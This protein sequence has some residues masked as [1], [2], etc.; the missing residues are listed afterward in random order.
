MILIEAKNVCKEFSKQKKLIVLE[1]FNLKVKKNEFV[2][3]IGPSGCGKSTFLLLAAGLEKVTT[4][5]IY[6]DGKPVNGPDPKRAIVFQEYLLFP[7]KTVRENIEFGPKVRNIEKEQRKK[8]SDQY[9]KL[10]GLEGFENQY[11]H[12]LSGGMKQRVAIARSLANE[13]EVLLMDEPFGALDALTRE[14]LQIE[15]LHIWQ[16]AKCTVLFVTH[17]IN[18]A[19]CL[20]DRVVIM[21]TRPGTIIADISIQLPRPRSRET[22]FSPEFKTYEQKLRQLVWTQ[23]LDEK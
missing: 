9:I 8:I 2:T 1:G 21:S 3:I 19:V 23:V 12:E 7:W 13:P 10:V 4:G 18:E 11:P 16:K 22:L 5:G 20:S 17:S 14:M 6:I 15:L